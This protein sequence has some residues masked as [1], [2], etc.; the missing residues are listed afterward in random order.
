M[1][2]HIKKTS[3]LDSHLVVMAASVVEVVLDTKMVVVDLV[4]DLLSMLVLLLV[5]TLLVVLL[6]LTLVV[7]VVVDLMETMMVALADLELLS[8]DTLVTSSSLQLILHYN[9]L[10]RLHYQLPRQQTLSC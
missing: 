2:Y 7:E 5:D 6:V 4:V 3:A 10:I 9:Q 8:L 1:A